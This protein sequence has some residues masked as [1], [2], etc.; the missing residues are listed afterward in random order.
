MTCGGSQVQVP[1]ELLSLHPRV[2]VV[3]SSAFLCLFIPVGGGFVY[4]GACGGQ[5]TI[6]HWYSL[7]VS[8]KSLCVAQAGPKLLLILLP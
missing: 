3:D 8:S 2:F 4:H 5:R 6:L 7:C 1:S